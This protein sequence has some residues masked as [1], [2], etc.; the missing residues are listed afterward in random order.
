MRTVALA[1]ESSGGNPT[2]AADTAES[3][4]YALIKQGGPSVYAPF[5]EQAVKAMEEAR[6]EQDPQV[7]ANKLQAVAK[8][9]PTA[10]PR[11]TRC[12]PPPTPMRPPTSRGAIR[13]LRPMWFKYQQSPEPRRDPRGDRP[14][15]PRW[16][17]TATAPRWWAP[18]PPGWRRAQLAGDPK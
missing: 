2:Q 16:S 18:P 12:S 9:T 7:K 1:D 14:Q 3:A 5:Q 6:A 13:V 17:A 8:P 4:I 11:P 15:L 10:P